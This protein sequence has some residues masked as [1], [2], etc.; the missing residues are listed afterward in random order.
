VLICFQKNISNCLKVFSSFINW[1]FFFSAILLT[2]FILHSTVYSQIAN[3]QPNELQKIDVEEH[4]GDKIPLDKSFVTD[5]GD[6][7]LLSDFFEDEK[8][9]IL[10]L[11]YYSCP[12]LCSMVL[13]GM[14]DAA[15]QIPFQL[16]EDYKILTIS[17]DPT[18][19]SKLASDKKSN[20]VKSWS[21]KNVG[22][23][24]TFFVGQENEIKSLADILGFKYYY[25]KDKK[26]YAHPAVLFVLTA[27][28]TISRY[29][30]GIQFKPNDL[31]LSLL[32]AAQGKIG[33]TFDKLLLY[34]YHYDPN[35]KGYAVF[36][37]NVM[38]LG[39]LATMLLLGIYLLILWN[40]YR[41]RHT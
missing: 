11:A 12:M 3:Y 18:E 1:R 20:Y 5:A 34:C 21:E 37:G 33:N 22:D 4:L 17:I 31:R 32:E 16:G 39:G 40:K 2:L 7:L 28:G 41:I 13:N 25:L 30:Y 29:L 10:V 27:D 38:R 8:P 26:E 35:S 19:T 15:K 14:I 23:N 24:W 36:A 9:V 6:T